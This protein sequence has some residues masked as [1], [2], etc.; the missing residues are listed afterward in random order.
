V[1]RAAMLRDPRIDPVPGDSI[2]RGFS[3]NVQIIREVERAHGGF[4]GFWRDNGFRECRKIVSL[5]KWRRWAKQA[6]ILEVAP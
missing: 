3:G 4:V 5:E 6:E 1:I 2:C